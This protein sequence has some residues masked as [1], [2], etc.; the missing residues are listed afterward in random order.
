MPGARA[1]RGAGRDRRR[2]ACAA[3]T[4]T[5]TSTAASGRYVVDAPLVLGHESAGRVVARRRRRST[6]H[7]V[8]DRV[9]LEPGVPCG[10]CRECRAGRY[11]L[12][13]DVVFFATP[14]VDGAF[15]E[16]RADPRGLRVRAARLAVRRGRRADGAA[17][18]RHLG[19]PQGG[20]QRRRPRA[21][22]R[23]RAD[24][25]AGHAGRAR[26]RRHRRS[27]SPT[28]TST[29]SSSPRRTGATRALA[30]ATTSPSEADALIECSGP[31]G[32]ADRRH[33]GAAPG[34]APRCSSAW[35]RA[36]PA[37]SRSR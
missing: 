32:R 4:S 26:V 27:R 10:R 13:P 22:H 23:R 15:A 16:L 12:C 24:R 33:H 21:R 6:K 5:T 3:P 7:A 9:T 34:R 20:R 14:P 36:R 25:A 29:G 2:S 28:S 8:G 30:P 19:V 17:V 31:P 18:G 1:A 35:A 11:N 37:R